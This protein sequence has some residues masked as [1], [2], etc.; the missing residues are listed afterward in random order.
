MTPGQPRHEKLDLHAGALARVAAGA[1]G[2]LGVALLAVAFVLRMH[3]ADERGAE[4]LASPAA[5]PALAPAPEPRLQVD[6]AADLQAIRAAE[7]A[8]LENYAWQDRPAEVVRIPVA[9]AMD[10]IAA[11]GLPEWKTENKP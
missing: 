11:R 5:G 6:S 7:R 1:V 10:L 4:T 2:A 8:H 3:R 9:R